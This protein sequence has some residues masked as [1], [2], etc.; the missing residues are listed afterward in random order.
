MFILALNI[1]GQRPLEGIFENL[2]Q[3]LLLPLGPNSFHIFR[4]S[5]SVSMLF[6]TGSSP[7]Y[8]NWSLN[9]LFSACS[10]LNSKSFASYDTELKLKFS[11]WPEFTWFSCVAQ[12]FMNFIHKI[13]FFL[14]DGF[15]KLSEFSGW[16]F[17]ILLNFPNF[18][19]QNRWGPFFS[20]FFF[21]SHPLNFPNLAQL[22]E[23]SGQTF[24]IW[25]NFPNFS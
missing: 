7:Y 21:R 19:S 5:L 12:R 6:S 16:T 17:R 8:V 4:A 18:S 14:I 15:P 23:F 20:F 10:C 1:E 22:S 2:N 11:S 9:L 25:L 3:E 24:R 13:P